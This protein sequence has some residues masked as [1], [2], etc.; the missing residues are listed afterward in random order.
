MFQLLSLFQETSENYFVL[1]A[2]DI[3]DIFASSFS[4]FLFLQPMEVIH[5]SRNK[6]T[7]LPPSLKMLF[8]VL[9]NV[10][11]GAVLRIP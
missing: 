4:F 5:L 6:C 7:N 8:P 9:C 2:D 3:R 10:S 11:N 1:V